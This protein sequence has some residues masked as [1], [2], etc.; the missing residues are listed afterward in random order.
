MKYA[1]KMMLVPIGR[2]TPTETK[3]SELELELNKILKKKNMSQEEKIKHY[4]QLLSRYLAMNENIKTQTDQ[5]VR[6]IESSQRKHSVYFDND[7]KKTNNSEV[8]PTFQEEYDYD[9]EYLSVDNDSRE[10][11][12]QLNLE[13]MTILNNELMK[14]SPSF[15]LVKENDKDVNRYLK[16]SKKNQKKLGRRKIQLLRDWISY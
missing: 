6:P 2:N 14:K 7:S 5:I 11:V 8:I 1:K 16:E 13:D 15:D 10:E 12:K 9:D 3:A 4:N